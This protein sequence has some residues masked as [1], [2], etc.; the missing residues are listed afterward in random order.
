MNVKI[1]KKCGK[2]GL[3]QIDFGLCWSY[4]KYRYRHKCKLCRSNETK[5]WRKD[6]PEHK[7]KYNEQWRKA[8]PV[9]WKQYRKNSYDKYKRWFE[10]NYD[11]LREYRNLHRSRKAG[12]DGTFD[13]GHL[14]HI[15]VCQEGLCSCCKRQLPFTKMTVD[16]VKPISK[17]GSSNWPNNIQ[18]L[19]K[20]C[21]SSKGNYHNIDYRDNKPVFFGELIGKYKCLE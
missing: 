18:L 6:N 10:D 17:P 3:D 20:S 12:L 13:K 7:R 8:N 5:Q 2:I 1:C 14:M 19:C 16:H 21:N 15:Y 4:G 11:K 9:Y